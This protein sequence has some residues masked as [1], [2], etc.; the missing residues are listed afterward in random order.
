M[1]K[2]TFFFAVQMSVDGVHRATPM[3][4]D[5]TNTELTATVV[6]L[7][8]NSSTSATVPAR[9]KRRWNLLRRGLRFGTLMFVAQRLQN[10]TAAHL[11][12][13]LGRRTF[14]RLWLSVVHSAYMAVLFEVLLFRQSQMR[15]LYPKMISILKN[16][17]V[18]EYVLADQ[19]RPCFESHSGVS[20]VRNAG[21]L[22][23]RFWLSVLPA[24]TVGNLLVHLVTGRLSRVRVATLERMWKAVL[25]LFLTSGVP[26]LVF[27]MHKKLTSDG[28]GRRWGAVLSAVCGAHLA[29]FTAPRSI[30]VRSVNSMY[31]GG[32]VLAVAQAFEQAVW[33][34]ETTGKT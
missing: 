7:H 26:G 1:Y 23:I 10:I 28:T 22:Y 18:E 9:A 12:H 5:D 6:P 27:C 16:M 34:T 13:F 11:F 8:L 33:S 14:P 15:T 17:G 32:A 25:F 19:T 4:L 31:V 29:V 24:A 20:C 2:L 3:A 21:R 30:S